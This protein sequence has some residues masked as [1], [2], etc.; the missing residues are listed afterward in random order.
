MSAVEYIQVGSSTFLSGGLFAGI[1]QQDAL[2]LPR[3][4]VTLDQLANYG[5][6]EWED[7]RKKGKDAKYTQQGKIP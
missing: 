1:A 6:S 4:T 5:P 7:L 2:K 3:P